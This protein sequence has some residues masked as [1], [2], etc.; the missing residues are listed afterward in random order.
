MLH[1]IYWTPANFTPCQTHKLQC[2]GLE[3]N[4]DVLLNSLG[5]LMILL[6]LIKACNASNQKVDRQ[7]KQ[8]NTNFAF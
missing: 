7:I 2:V 6:L 5:T 3:E 4:P 8:Q 1:I